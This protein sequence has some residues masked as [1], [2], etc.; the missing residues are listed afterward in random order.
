VGV[1]F[2]GRSAFGWEVGGLFV[3]FG[4]GEYEELTCLGV[5]IDG[6]VCGLFR[7]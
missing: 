1:G 4:D 7:S 2:F 6:G 5:L 3:L